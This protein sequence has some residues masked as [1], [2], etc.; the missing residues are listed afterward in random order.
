MY[1]DRKAHALETW[2]R[3]L[4][5][6]ETRMSAPEQY[7]ELLRLAE[8]YCEEGFITREERRAMIER[9]TANYRQAVEG[10]GQGT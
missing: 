1:E 3:L 4:N 6:P 5:H 2:K 10:I 8:E 7:D 9:A